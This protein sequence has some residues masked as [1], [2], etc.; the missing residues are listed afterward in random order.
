MAIETHLPSAVLKSVA[1]GFLALVC[2]AGAV[3]A[4]AA[5]DD[6]QPKLE[7]PEK[8]TVIGRYER[9]AI[10]DGGTVIKAKIDTGAD[11]SSVDAREVEPFER[12]G[13]E[14]VRF[15]L[16]TGDETVQMERK[17]VDTVIIVN[18]NGRERRYVV[19]IDFC[20]GDIERTVEVNLADREGLDFR[21]LIGREFLEATNTLVNV[22]QEYSFDPACDTLIDR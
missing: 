1:G 6:E 15:E 20:I 22:A 21:M 8:L 2:A 19:D 14:W 18:S 17:V 11:S 10:A 12:D 9:V 4:Q 13:E 7:H 16:M 5:T 3:H